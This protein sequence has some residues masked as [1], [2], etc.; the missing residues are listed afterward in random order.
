MRLKDAVMSTIRA[1]RKKTPDSASKRKTA[2]IIR[3]RLDPLFIDDI[4]LP[5]V[6]L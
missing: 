4:A 6:V 5:I 3:R 2:D 1:K